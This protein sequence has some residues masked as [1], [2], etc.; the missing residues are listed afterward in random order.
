MEGLDSLRG[1]EPT[2]SLL[3]YSTLSMAVCALS[4]ALHNAS[5]LDISPPPTISST[6]LKKIPKIPPTVGFL[7]M[8]ASSMT[9]GRLADGL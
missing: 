3:V 1:N 6:Q 2:P 7:D 8:T 4:E 9:L 5:K